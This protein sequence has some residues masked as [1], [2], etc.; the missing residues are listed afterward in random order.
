MTL[1]ELASLSYYLTIR[2]RCHSVPQKYNLS[3]NIRNMP[4]AVAVLSELPS[5]STNFFF[6][7]Q[8]NHS[9]YF[10]F[11]RPG[12]LTV[13]TYWSYSQSGLVWVSPWSNDQS[14]PHVTCNYDALSCIWHDII[15]QTGRWTCVILP[16]WPSNQLVT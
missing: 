6:R 3:Y 10:V 5:T 15:W 8:L 11:I 9:F 1:T 2:C 4:L 14:H 7:F 16:S 12:D 13:Q